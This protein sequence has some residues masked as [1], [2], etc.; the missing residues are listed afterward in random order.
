MKMS[1]AL[2]F[3]VSLTLGSF[4]HH[5]IKGRPGIAHFRR[6]IFFQELFQ[7]VKKRLTHN[8]IVFFMHTESDGMT[9][10]EGLQYWDEIG[11]HIQA[12]DNDRKH[13]HKFIALLMNI[14]VKKRSCIRGKFKQSIIATL[15]N[16]FG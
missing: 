12:A 9:L 11:D 14:A 5:I 10:T 2:L 13:L 4:C 7:A 15:C 16:L 1:L 8:I 3:A 6:K